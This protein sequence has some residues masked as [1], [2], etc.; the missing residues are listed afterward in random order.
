[1]TMLRTIQTSYEKLR[2]ADITGSEPTITDFK[3]SAR[4][5]D[6]GDV[7]TKWFELTEETNGAEIIP[8]QQDATS[9]KNATMQFW[10][11]ARH[12]GPAQFIAEISGTIGTASIINDT[13]ALAWDTM[14]IVLDGRPVNIAVADAT[15]NNRPASITF[16][17]MGL[18]YIKPIWTDITPS[19]GNNA[20][21]RVY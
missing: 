15:G 20:W 7:S 6:D 8:Y 10:G 14:N 19:E 18:R 16:D 3:S 1:M 13:T 5:V 2:G 4:V 12:N 9:N 17:T 21:I 11:R